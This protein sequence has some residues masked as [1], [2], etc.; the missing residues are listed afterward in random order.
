MEDLWLGVIT[1]V[2]GIVG[3]LSAIWL[4]FY[5][6]RKRK[7][8][9]ECPVQHAVADDKEILLRLEEIRDET[10]A[11]RVSVFSFHNGG[12][13]Y[14]GKSMQKLSCSYEVVVPGVARQQITMQNIPVSACHATLQHLMENKEFHCYDVDANY[15]ESG[16]KASLQD[17]GVK[18]TYQYCIFDL[19]RKAIG[20]LRADFVL[21]CEEL[22]DESHEALKYTAIK[23]S[24]YLLG[25]N[26][27][28]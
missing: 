1:T 7:E 23:L 9:V 21:N 11:D 20:L 5:L 3:T 24:G 2:L 8:K 25:T 28:K 16:C 19:N 10:S 14:S 13:Y 4:K 26:G 12:E 15:P 18:S 27:K 6:E 17:F 22:S